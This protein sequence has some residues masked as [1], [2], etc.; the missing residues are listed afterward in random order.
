MMMRSLKFVGLKYHQT[1]K[2][3]LALGPISIIQRKREESSMKVRLLL[4]AFLVFFSSIINS[5]IYYCP[6]QPI[7]IEIGKTYNGHWFAWKEV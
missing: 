6:K 5:S 4:I 2:L 7:D 3:E 1:R